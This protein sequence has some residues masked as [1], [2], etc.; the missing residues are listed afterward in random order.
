MTRALCPGLI[1]NP[2]RL[3]IEYDA[4]FKIATTGGGGSVDTWTPKTGG[5]AADVCVVPF[6][7][8]TYPATYYPDYTSSDSDYGGRP[9]VGGNADAF[10]LSTDPTKAFRCP[11][12]STEIVIARLGAGTTVRQ[13]VVTGAAY[14]WEHAFWMPLEPD[15]DYVN[16]Y[17]G[18]F[19][20][21]TNVVP[22]RTQ[23]G[24]YVMRYDSSNFNVDIHYADGSTDT[25]SGTPPSGTEIMRGVTFLA[26][27]DGDEQAGTS[28]ITYYAAYAGLFRDFEVQREIDKWVSA[29]SWS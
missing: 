13:R 4:A 5:G 27:P 26:L 16:W 8:V 17:W 19:Y 10:L 22:D 2:K 18:D 15:Y 20:I 11:Q 23:A 21:F 6:S 9:S 24:I 7:G 1:P 14:G 29:M 12:P 25:D 3:I 28:T